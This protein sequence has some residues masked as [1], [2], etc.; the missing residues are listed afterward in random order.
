M[1]PLKRAG[2]GNQCQALISQLCEKSAWHRFFVATLLVAGCLAGTNA[3]A[4]ERGKA[5]RLYTKGLAEMHAGRGDA[6][7]VLFQQA[8][9]A[10][11]QDVHAIY[12]RGL[13]YGKAGRY[14]EAADDLRVVVAA[15]DSAVPRARLEL[16]YALY[17]LE[18][19][20]EAA[21]ELEIASKEEAAHAGEA[22]LLLGIVEIRRG[23]NEAARADLAKVETLD[24]KLAVQARYYQGLAAW[25]AGD[26]EVAETHFAWVRDQP[27]D[28]VFTREAQAFLEG[29]DSAGTGRPYR[30]HAGF[31]L[32]YDSNVVLA[33]EDDAIAEGIY[34]ISDQDDGRALFT[35]GGQY[36]VLSRPNLRIALGYDFLQSLHFDLEE[37]DIQTHRAGFEGA[38]LHG[39][40]T[41]GLS[42]AYDFSLLD[43]ES[44]L[45]AGT[46]LPWARWDEG[47]FGRTEAYY[48]MRPRD[49]VLEPYDPVR[50]SIN[51]A[52]G[53][54]Q[55]FSLG[56]RNRNIIVGYRYDADRADKTIGEQ[57][58]YDG[59]Q[60][61]GG[62]QWDFGN[63]LYA[64]AL[65]A[66]KLENY[67]G[68]SASP[69]DPS[70]DARD[71]DEHTVITRVEKRVWD[72]VWLKASY[73]FRDNQSDQESFD[74][75]RHIASLGVEVRY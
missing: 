66:Y 67:D 44:L 33:P 42:G 12:Y 13:G 38:W 62:L 21:A 15:N 47:D 57:F 14:K 45:H 10:D 71:D 3:G 70:L 64:D 40:L 49:F 35:A 73:I 8:V 7:L 61:E 37:F 60:F 68:A 22:M 5:E 50:D 17:R 24:P 41:I 19:F 27:G 46:I 26:R 54:R 72:Y 28:M 53:V 20:D 43:N 52:V 31:A 9:E 29:G 74:Y 59:H 25:R 48:R 32:E 39:A 34:G 36:A 16:G 18:R 63:D 75:G 11:P 1:S 2:I 4:S 65:Y 69:F 30:L 23:H 55:F 6:A 58:D 51:H 56:A